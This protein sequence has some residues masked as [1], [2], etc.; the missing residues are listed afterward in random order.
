MGKSVIDA[1]TV[2]LLLLTNDVMPL[3]FP[4]IPGTG[5]I[6]VY[7]PTAQLLAGE[8]PCTYMKA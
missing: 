5:F 1:A 3:L 8:T 6:E 2:Y 4:E 7:P